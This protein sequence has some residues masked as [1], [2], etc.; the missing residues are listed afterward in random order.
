MGRQHLFSQFLDRSSRKRAF[1]V[2]RLAVSECPMMIKWFRWRIRDVDEDRRISWLK[3]QILRKSQGSNIA[4]REKERK[5]STFG[6]NLATQIS[7]VAGDHG[8]RSPA[9]LDFGPLSG[10]LP[11]AVSRSFLGLFRFCFLMY[12]SLKF[13]CIY[14]LDSSE[15]NPSKGCENQST[16]SPI[17]WK[18]RRLCSRFS[19]KSWNWVKRCRNDLKFEV[20]LLGH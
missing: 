1:L 14:W 2:G 17:F 18:S 4:K 5:N 13:L 19:A 6:G 9:T 12:F 8:P 16:K 7:R 11:V 10:R 3:N 15:E 20:K